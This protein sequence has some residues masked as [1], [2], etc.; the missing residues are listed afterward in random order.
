VA[1]AVDRLRRR[2]VHPDL[3]CTVTA[4]VAEDPLGTYRRLRDLGGTFLQFLPIVRRG[5]DGRPTPESVTPEAYGRFLCAVFDEWVGHDLG[6]VVV[7]LF[8]EAV[9]A[10]A[11]QVPGLC[12]MAPTCGRVLVLEHDGAVYSCDHFVDPAH[13][14]G[15][16]ATVHL[17][18]WPITPPRSSSGPTSTTACPPSV[19]SVPGLPRA[20][21]AARRTGS[22]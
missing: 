7:Q 1:A 4:M 8:G 14:L 16:V 2:G 17:A 13:R 11:G 21:A 10:W 22:G 9:R 20:T 15:N 6:T 19:G 5:P 18:R 3:L 12:V